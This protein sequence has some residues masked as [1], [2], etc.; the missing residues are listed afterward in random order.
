M[1]L[2]DSKFLQP[3]RATLRES[4][5]ETSDDQTSDGMMVAIPRPAEVAAV[6]QMNFLRFII[7]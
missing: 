5:G 4:F 7:T 6:L 3:I 2:K 1:M